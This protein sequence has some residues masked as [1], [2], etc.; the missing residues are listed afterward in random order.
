MNGHKGASSFDTVSKQVRSV[1]NAAAS[2]SQKR[3]RERRTYQF[4]S[5]STRLAIARPAVVASYASRRSVTS[6]AVAA[7]RDSAQRSRSASALGASTWSAP[8][9]GAP[10]ELVPPLA[11]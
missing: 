2:P 10:F 7:V 4:D 3:L 1:W 8:A 9:A 5:S 6:S 11:L